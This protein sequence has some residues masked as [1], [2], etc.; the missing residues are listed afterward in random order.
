MIDFRYHLVSIIAVFLALAIG[1]VLGSTALQGSTID[2]LRALSGSLRGQLNATSADRNSWKQAAQANDAFLQVAE[3]KLLDGMLAGSRIVLVTEPGA[4]SSV[5]NGVQDAAKLAGAAITGTVA[6]APKFNDLSGATRAS[7]STINTD[8]SSTNGIGLAP[9]NDPE[10]A[11]QQEA[12]QVIATA[13]VGQAD[14]QLGLDAQSA[15]TLLGS[16][17]SSGYLTTNG[18]P[19]K[20]RATL[21]VIVTAPATAADGQGDP[22]D[23]VLL[24]VAGEFANA[25][26]ATLVAGPTLSPPESASAITVLRGNSVS[27]LVTTVD[28]ADTRAGQITAMWALANQ[29]QGGKPG[30]Y[31]VS[32]GVSGISPVPSPVLTATP[33]PT[34]TPTKGTTGKAKKT[35]STK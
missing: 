30:S 27:T 8:L 35:V 31:G 33:T 29:L 4:S 25:S 19:W 5:V 24:A 26:A 17:A 9:A 22:A 13:I 21:A 12:A 15:Q 28:N 14:G 10:T 34:G 32:S 16:Y 1:I 18:T 23:R 20:D 3:P 6:L 2:G 7:L 11:Y